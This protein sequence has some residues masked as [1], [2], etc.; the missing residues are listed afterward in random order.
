MDPFLAAED[1]RNL[2]YAISY[3][4]EVVKLK[5]SYPYLSILNR[6]VSFYSDNKE[7]VEFIRKYSEAIYTEV[8]KADYLIF[9]SEPDSDTLKKIKRG[10]LEFP[11]KGATLFLKINKIGEGTKILMRGPGIKDSIKINL[12]ISV[13]FFKILHEINDF[14]I[15]IDI[16]FIDKDR[17]IV[18][19]PRSVEVKVWDL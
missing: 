6:D 5:T 8:E 14:P 10:D 17:N 19:I 1:F 12:S 7:E 18:A 3:P 13:N 16:F 4:G 2:L 11:E 15:G 9:H